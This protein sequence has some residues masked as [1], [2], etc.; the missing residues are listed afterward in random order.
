MPVSRF[1]SGAFFAMITGLL[2]QMGGLLQNKPDLGLGPYKPSQ[3]S[4]GSSPTST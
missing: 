1:K 2:G 3:I 4:A